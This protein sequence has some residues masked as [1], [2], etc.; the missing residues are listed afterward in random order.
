MGQKALAIKRLVNS[1]IEIMLSKKTRDSIQNLALHA[2]T[3]LHFCLLKIDIGVTLC[4]FWTK[5]HKY[6]CCVYLS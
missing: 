3:E 5:K 1:L 6:C 2:S 4:V